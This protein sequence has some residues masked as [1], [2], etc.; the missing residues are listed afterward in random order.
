VATPFA[1][2]GYETSLRDGDLDLLQPFAGEMYAYPVD[3]VLLKDRDAP[4]CLQEMRIAG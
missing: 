3:K 4:E 2:A 1:V